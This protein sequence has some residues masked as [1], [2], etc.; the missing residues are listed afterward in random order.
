MLTKSASAAGGL[1]L[2][3]DCGAFGFA[4][5]G[6][7]DF[8]ALPGEGEGGGAADARGGAGDDGNFVFECVV[9]GCVGLDVD[10]E[11]VGGK[12][13][14]GRGGVFVARGAIAGGAGDHGAVALRGQAED[15][16]VFRP[17]RCLPSG[18]CRCRRARRRS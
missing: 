10:D 13:D 17:G 8:R 6:E 3:D 2:R 7:D 9:H 1:D 18:R 12:A 4:P 5:A 15:L 14:L 11:F 16:V